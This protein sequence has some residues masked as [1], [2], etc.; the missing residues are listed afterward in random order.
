MS[1]LNKLKEMAGAAGDF[2]GMDGQMGYQGHQAQ[3]QFGGGHEPAQPMPQLPT[4]R[5]M[6]APMGVVNTQGQTQWNPTMGG[7]PLPRNFRYGASGSDLQ[8]IDSINQGIGSEYGDYDL[9]N[10][11][12]PAPDVVSTDQA[13]RVIN[14]ATGMGE[15]FH[16]ADRY[17]KLPLYFRGR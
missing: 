1:I 12:V 7:A 9:P 3:G 13:L 15:S 17:M 10:G 2:V 5:Q 6:M 14:D 11:V 4:H 16:A 8:A